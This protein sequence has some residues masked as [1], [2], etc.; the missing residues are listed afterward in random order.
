MRTINITAGVMYIVLTTALLVVM[1]ATWRKSKNM[2]LIVIELAL[3]ISSIFAGLAG[4]SLNN[5]GFTIDV[6]KIILRL[7]T[8]RYSGKSL[9]QAYPINLKIST[10]I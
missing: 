2:L 6:S 9:S 4:R 5:K 7:I 8:F 1:L 10:S 3:I